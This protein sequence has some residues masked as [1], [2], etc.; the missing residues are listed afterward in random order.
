MLKYKCINIVTYTGCSFHDMFIIIITVLSSG[1]S[2]AHVCMHA[3]ACIH[4]CTCTCMHAHACIHM[5]ACA[6]MNAHAC[7]H[8]CMHT[9]AK[10]LPHVLA[11]VCMHVHTYML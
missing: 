1:R 7:M 9:C 2:L 10:D 8:A 6:C 5:H 3:Y 11:H 4:V